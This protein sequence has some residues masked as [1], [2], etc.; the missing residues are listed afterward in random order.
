MKLI[1]RK[2]LFLCF[3]SLCNSLFSDINSGSPLKL[4]FVRLFPVKKPIT[5]D[6]SYS[7]LQKFEYFNKPSFQFDRAV[8]EHWYIYKIRIFTTIQAASYCLEVPDF[9]VNKMDVYLKIHSSDSF[10]H[11]LKYGDELPVSEYT[12]SSRSCRM[13]L[14]KLDKG[15]YLL[16]IKYQ[17]AGVRP[18]LMLKINPFEKSLRNWKYL[19]VL[20]GIVFGVLLAYVLYTFIVLY[21]RRT[22]TFVYFALWVLM[23]TIY[24]SISSGHFKYYLRIE[25]LD[26][27]SGIRQ[28]SAV[29]AIYAIQQFAL[30]HYRMDQ[31]LK[32]V[33]N[34][35]H[36]FAALTVLLNLYTIVTGQVFYEG[37]EFEFLVAVR[38]VIAIFIIIQFY[39]PTYYYLKYKQFSFFIWVLVISLLNLLTF[40]IQQNFFTEVDFEQYSLYTAALFTTEVVVIAFGTIKYTVI[41]RAKYQE[42]IKERSQLVDQQNQ[43]QFISQE[44]ERK[45]I[46]IDLHDDV[47]N[48]LSMNYMLFQGDYIDKEK[49]LQALN[50]IKFNINRYSDGFFFE[51]KLANENMESLINILRK[52]YPHLEIVFRFNPG[53]IKLIESFIRTQ[54]L[55]IVQEFVKNSVIHGKAT[56]VSIDL[57][58]KSE[59][60]TLSLL[61]N[62]RGFDKESTRKGLG[63]EGVEYRVF[64]LNGK[65]GTWSEPNKGVSWTII[66]PLQNTHLGELQNQSL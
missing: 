53:S 22:P 42:S 18:N 27:I 28:S 29:L 62:G 14:M 49:M 39:L 21:L 47:L 1:F 25:D 64:S 46:A 45:K 16:L 54:I 44:N 15:E 4:E 20:F 41:E 2:T 48:R 40:I 6:S 50:D 19:E 63:T 56:K 24:Y 34:Y 13:P 31:K 38:V 10:Q 17:R 43:L 60:I 59:E 8:P 30:I 12:V 52:T 55:R 33:V 35:G 66:I 65:F 3:F 61:D 9:Q 57:E 32:W 51:L 37:Y 26:F 7:L 23:N 5:V 36:A 11:L 58:A